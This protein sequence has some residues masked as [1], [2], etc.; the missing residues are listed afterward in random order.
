VGNVELHLGGNNTFSVI[1]NAR[2]VHNINIREGG[3][4]GCAKL[5]FL[6][7]VAVQKALKAVR[8]RHKN[9]RILGQM[10]DHTIL[11]LLA[12]CIL[13]YKDLRD[14][15]LAELNLS[16][17][18]TKAFVTGGAA[19]LETYEESV[20][21][22]QKLELVALDAH[23]VKGIKIGGAPIGNDAF[24]RAF[25][26]ER[27]GKLD[28]VA[29]LLEAAAMDSEHVAPWQGLFALVKNCVAPRF[30]FLARVLLPSHSTPFAKQV[31]ARMALLALRVSGHQL[32]AS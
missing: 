10:D 15:F 11:G 19:F 17:N 23:I 5:P 8:E 22:E 26:Q 30:H 20:T 3:N 24:V 12:D 29:T 28:A 9:V 14:T 4:T 16:M 13:A 6:F 27:L 25:L 2:A 7:V 18:G 1:D 32:A 31:D 21:E